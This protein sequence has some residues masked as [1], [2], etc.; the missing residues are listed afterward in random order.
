MIISCLGARFTGKP[1]LSSRRL[2]V[3]HNLTFQNTWHGN[4]GN[5]F[6]KLIEYIETYG[7]HKVVD[8]TGNRGIFF[9]FSGTDKIA[10]GDCFLMKATPSRH[11]INNYDGGKETYFNRVIIEENKGGT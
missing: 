11:Q 8:K 4:R 9:S 5:F 3:K 6:V 2:S 1:G 7:L 10:K